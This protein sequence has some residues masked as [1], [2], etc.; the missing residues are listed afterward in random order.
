MQKLLIALHDVTPAH[1]VRLER[2]ERFFESQGI[3][4]IAYLLVPDFHGS[5]PA[6]SS[7]FVQWCNGTRPYEIQWLLHGYFHD[8][9]LQPGE[10]VSRRH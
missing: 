4:R 3:D 5:C 8:D 7:E 2:A 6:A 10:D 9:R 1:W